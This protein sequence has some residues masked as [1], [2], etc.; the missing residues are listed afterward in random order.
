VKGERIRRGG[1]E[2]MQRRGRRRGGHRRRGRGDK[3]KGRSGGRG[4]D[5]CVRERRVS[6]R[7]EMEGVQMQHFSCEILSYLQ[8]KLSFSKVVAIKS[9]PNIV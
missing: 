6:R 1:R 2:G 9:H 5:V 8:S 3:G 4:A 7:G